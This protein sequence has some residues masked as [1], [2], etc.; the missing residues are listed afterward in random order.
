MR[1]NISSGTR[2]E[3][4]NAYSRAVRIGPHVWVAGTTAVDAEGRIV[5]EGDA[6][7]QAAFILRKIGKALKEAG[8]ELAD[9]VRT[10]MYLVSL[11]DAEAVGRAHAEIFRDIRPAATMIQIAGLVDPRLR[12]EIEAEANVNR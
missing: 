11:D 3:E 6:Y 9:V 2:W 12:V 5:G 10:R 7:G 4:Q 1:T 8:A